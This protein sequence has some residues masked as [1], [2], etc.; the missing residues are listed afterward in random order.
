MKF[1]TGTAMYG[2]VKIFYD[3]LV[4]ERLICG[5]ITIKIKLE[6]KIVNINFTFKDRML[7]VDFARLFICIEK[8]QKN[9]DI[10]IS[11]M[12]KASLVKI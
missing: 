8:I 6:E 3:K 1:D 5:G 10:V 7:T 4:Y 2:S 9:G 12:I 11:Y